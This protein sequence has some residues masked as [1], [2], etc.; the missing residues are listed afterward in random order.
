[1]YPFS[2]KDRRW[3]CERSE[4]SLFIDYLYKTT[5]TLLAVSI[6]SNVVVVLASSGVFWLSFY[7][8]NDNQIIEFPFLGKK[9]YTYVFDPRIE[10]PQ[11]SGCRFEGL[12][13]PGG[14][15]PYC[16]RAANM[17]INNMCGAKR[18]EIKIS[19]SRLSAVFLSGRA[20]WLK[21]KN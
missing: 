21:F 14:C 10:K 7:S 19:N 1:M 17:N 18:S 12:V 2:C 8:K 16:H 20:F 6:L 11:Q 5:T 15:M 4:L 13:A 3:E 9:G